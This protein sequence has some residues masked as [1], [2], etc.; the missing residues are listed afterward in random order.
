MTRACQGSR[1]F[2]AVLSSAAATAGG[3]L[4]GLRAQVSR[5]AVTHRPEPTSDRTR[6]VPRQLTV[7]FPHEHVAWLEAA[8]VAVQARFRRQR[9]QDQA[10]GHALEAQ[11]ARHAG[12]REQR[13]GHRR[14]RQEARRPVEEHR[15]GAER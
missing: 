5:H 15:P 10:V 9:H 7:Q 11:P 2:R 4:P 3:R 13:P 14:E 6:P 8:D 12:D 1:A